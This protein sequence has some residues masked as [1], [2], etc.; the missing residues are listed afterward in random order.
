MKLIAV[1]DDI[2]E[3]PEAFRA[4]YVEFDDGGTKKFKL[5]I[6]GV[7]THPGT[8]ALK[9]ALDRQ[10]EKV[11]T[12]TGE[13]AALE[14]RLIDV[15]EDFDADLYNRAVTE[16][17]GGGKI[18]NE[19]EIRREAGEAAKQRAE[20]AFAKDKTK[21][22]GER[23]AYRTQLVSRIQ[24]D[25][26]R[27]A[28]DEAGVEDPALRKGAMALLRGSLTVHEDEGEIVVLANDVN[29]GDIPVADHVKAWA[30]TDEGKVYVGVRDTAGGGANGSPS[31]GKPT[32]TV[33][34]PWAKETFNVTEQAR[35]RREDID[36]ARRLAREAGVAV[37]F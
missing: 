21:L 27:D 32:S 10:K 8:Q 37:S 25:E 26:L 22:E 30:D 24:N 34:N 35:L 14:T 36:K 3:V 1:V 29:L 9:N 15:P 7:E 4:C 13:K 33:N 18:K 5:D 28:L 11:T 16:G 20:A 12:L 31:G 19:D 23:D 17:V 2:N 6:S